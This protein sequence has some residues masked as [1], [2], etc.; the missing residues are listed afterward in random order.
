[1]D[2]TM[3]SSLDMFPNEQVAD[4]RQT[5]P[6]DAPL[7]SLSEYDTSGNITAQAMAGL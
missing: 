3:D 6:Q 2:V 1:M 4:S 7:N 5:V